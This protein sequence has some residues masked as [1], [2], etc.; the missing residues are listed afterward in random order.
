MATAVAPGKKMSMYGYYL[1]VVETVVGKGNAQM[2]L[3]FLYGRLVS[4]D[5]PMTTATQ[6]LFNEIAEGRHKKELGE[7]R[8]L[9]AKVL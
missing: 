3:S 9:V 5:S 8:T 7:A 4:Q 6:F 2:V 1:D